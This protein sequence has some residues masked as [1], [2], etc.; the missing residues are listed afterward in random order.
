MLQAIVKPKVYKSKLKTMEAN[1][2][3]TEGFAVQC[4]SVALLRQ[5]A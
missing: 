3:E 4:E 1:V 2:K 5:I